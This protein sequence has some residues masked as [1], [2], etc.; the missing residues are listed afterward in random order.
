MELAQAFIVYAEWIFF[1]AWGTALAALAAVAFGRDIA[2]PIDDKA[3]SGN[4]KL[5]VAHSL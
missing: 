3:R 5:P 4:P 1:T 2:A